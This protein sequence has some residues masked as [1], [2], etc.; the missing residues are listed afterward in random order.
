MDLVIRELRDLPD[1]RA[2]RVQQAREMLSS[3]VPSP[4]M[5]AGK[6]IGRVLSD[7]IR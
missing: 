7:S 4:D 1:V 5:V 6:L 3:E 2:D